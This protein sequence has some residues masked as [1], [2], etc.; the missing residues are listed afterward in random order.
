MP[1]DV[2]ALLQLD[3]AAGAAEDDGLLDGG[4]VRERLVGVALERDRSAA[5]PP[6]VLRDQ[7]LAPHVVQAVGERVG[8]EAAEDDR[9]R[10]AEAGAREHR[11]R[12]LGNHPH[13]DPDRR[14]LADAERS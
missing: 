6:L 7:H 9:V 12:Q 4:R 14:P 11:D 5:P 1:P 3:V 8:G 2:A 13:V 10:R